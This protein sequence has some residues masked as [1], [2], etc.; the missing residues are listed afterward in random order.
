M[1][2]KFYLHIILYY[3]YNN[4]KIFFM[5]VTSKLPLYNFDYK[6][7]IDQAVVAYGETGTGKSFI[8][9][10]I[11]KQ[12]QPH[13]D[14]IFV[15]SPTDPTNGTYSETGIVKKPYIHYTLTIEFLKN[16][17]KR[18]EALAAIYKSVNKLEVLTSLYKRIHNP[19]VNEILRKLSEIKHAK[20][21]EIKDT[22]LEE[23][24]RR[25]KIE[26]LQKTL[27]EF[28][29][30]LYKKYIN[31]N[32]ERLMNMQNLSDEEKNTL[33]FLNINPRTVLVLDD[34]GSDLKAILNSKKDKA[35]INKFFYQGRW[36][37][38]TLIIACQNDMDIDVNWRKNVS[39]SFFTSQECASAYFNRANNDVPEKL[40]KQVKDICREGEI[41]IQEQNFYKMCYHRKQK[42]VYK[43]LA[44]KHDKF[45]FGS[46]LIKDYANIIA[47][48]GVSVDKNNEFYQM[49]MDD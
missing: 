13:V 18:Q 36:A 44:T 25:D 34:C 40:R 6:H 38:I 32:R 17:W 5:S 11:L 41:L 24:T 8:I 42:K 48:D 46:P 27:N 9:T 37:Y 30:I 23:S 4:C 28:L 7:Y 15:V 2:K 39:L 43:V 3:I 16:I 22:Y 26:E 47:N 21:R 49:L 20:I 29:S 12:L 1:Y 10:D 35:F 31:L 14:Q 19:R 33:K 45:T